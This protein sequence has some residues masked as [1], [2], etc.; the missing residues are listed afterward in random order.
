[1]Q[2]DEIV[3]RGHKTE[4]PT[5]V[6]TG[7]SGR[8]GRLLAKRL[9]REGKYRIVGID[10]RSFSDRPPDIVHS[11]VDLRSKKTRGVFRKERPVALVHLGLMHDPRKSRKEHHDWNVVGTSRLLEY[12]RRYNV[13]KVV[14]LSS[15]Y[16]Y[17]ARPENPQFLS[18]E[19]PLLGAQDTPGLRDLVEADMLANSFFWKCSEIST[20]ILRPVHV[21]GRVQNAISNLLRMKRIPKLVGFDPM[22]Q[23]IHEKD[24][25]ESLILSLSPKAG[26][27]YNVAGPGEIPYSVILEELGKPI[28]PIPHFCPK[29]LMKFL[30]LT[31]SSPI[32]GPEMDHLRFISMIDDSRIRKEL[33]FSP[34]YSIK[35]TIGSVLEHPADPMAVRSDSG[36]TIAKRS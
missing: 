18:E 6:I 31:G 14:F 33:G 21:L 27:V 19:A 23:L 7:I 34:K 29:F 8:I 26:G 22:M 10:R 35:E 28:L 5:I 24:V 13:P 25:V 9:H 30:W 4:K 1:M 2:E 17:G 12:C 15:H 20:V 16:V 11:R 32:E 36:T 3:M